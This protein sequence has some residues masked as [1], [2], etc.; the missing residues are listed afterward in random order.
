[1]V[2][3]ELTQVP[4]ITAAPGMIFA[5]IRFAARMSFLQWEQLSP[6]RWEFEE[7]EH[8]RGAWPQPYRPQIP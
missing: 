6:E 8:L 3:A 2:A 5:N 1:M 4:R 7:E